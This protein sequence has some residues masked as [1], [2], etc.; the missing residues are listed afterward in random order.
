LIRRRIAE[1]PTPA[2]KRRET[3]FEARSC[4]RCPGRRPRIWTGVEQ[5]LT[6]LTRR[7]NRVARTLSL[8]S[9]VKVIPIGATDVAARSHGPE[10]IVGA[11]SQPGRVARDPQGA[12]DGRHHAVAGLCEL[13]LETRALN[14]LARFY[15]E[16]LGLE[17]LSRARDRIWLACGP[18]ARLG[19]WT[20]G[21]KEFGDRGGRHV[22]FALSVEPGRLPTIAARARAGGGLVR[23]PV[24]HDGGDRSLY[25][26][27]PE[28]N[29]VELWDFFE[30]GRD[31]GSL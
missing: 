2:A 27:D 17:V 10:Q 25:L 14:E 20:P 6:N 24:E 13:T 29:V 23:G 1:E 19:L 11:H 18:R 30:R 4:G 5:A 28:G 26:E 16:L 21:A 15:T 7:G 3:L 31:V 12:R 8:I 9:E 22:H